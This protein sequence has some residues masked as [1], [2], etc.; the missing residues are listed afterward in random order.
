MI[1]RNEIF[2]DAEIQFDFLF[3]IF[4]LSESKA[5]ICIRILQIR[6][7]LFPFHLHLPFCL[8]FSLWFIFPLTSPRVWLFQMDHSSSYFGSFPL[9]SPDKRIQRSH[10]RVRK[11]DDV[12]WEKFKRTKVAKGLQ[13]CKSFLNSFSSWDPSWWWWTTLLCLPFLFSFLS[14]P[15]DK[16]CLFSDSPAPLFSLT[17]LI[18]PHSGEY[19]RRHMIY[20]HSISLLFLKNFS[21]TKRS[22]DLHIFWSSFC[23]SL[24]N[25][26]YQYH[27]HHPHHIWWWRNRALNY[28]NIF[29]PHH[30]S[31]FVSTHCI[32]IYVYHR[33]KHPRVRV[34]IMKRHEESQECVSSSSGFMSIIQETRRFRRRRVSS[35]WFSSSCSSCLTP[36]YP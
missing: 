29:Y 12:L 23:Y 15:H 6:Y 28:L 8:L 11:W 14:S 19:K 22:V 16:F 18:H 7:S 34:R 1:W 30:S 26:Y 31:F 27:D 10:E 9:L 5:L 4:L 13:T 36:S 17:I 25:Y 21:W 33:V 24:Y 20:Y 3:S 2:R 35:S 32:R